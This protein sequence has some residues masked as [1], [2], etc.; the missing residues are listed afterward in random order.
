[1]R[2]RGVVRLPDHLDVVQGPET[3]LNRRVSDARGQSNRERGLLCA[4]PSP[5]ISHRRQITIVW[6]FNRQLLNQ[7]TAMQLVAVHVSSGEEFRFICDRCSMVSI[8]SSRGAQSP[9]SHSESLPSVR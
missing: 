7:T 6:S 2:A 4:S 9:Q 3:P 1:M 8:R 5:I